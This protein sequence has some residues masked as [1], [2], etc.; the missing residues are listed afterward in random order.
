METLVMALMAIGVYGYEGEDTGDR[1]E[2]LSFALEY[3]SAVHKNVSW[4]LKN[5]D[6]IL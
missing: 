2:L 4:N 3:F 6:D 1:Y 5:I